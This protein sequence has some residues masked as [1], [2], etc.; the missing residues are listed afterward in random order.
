MTPKFKKLESIQGTRKY[1]I[2][3]DTPEVGWYLTVFENG[4]C[5]ADHLQ[6]NIQA[7]IKQAE[8]EYSVPTNSWIEK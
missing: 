5:V 4:Q 7:V 2:E 8:E 3:Q 1:L 6:N